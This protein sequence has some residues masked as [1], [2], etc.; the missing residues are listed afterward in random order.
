MLNLRKMDEEE[1]EYGVLNI[2]MQKIT[3]LVF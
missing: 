3:K 1:H 2:K